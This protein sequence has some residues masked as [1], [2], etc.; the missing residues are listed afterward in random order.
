MVEKCI[1]IWAKGV[2]GL[3]WLW[4]RNYMDKLSDLDFAI[5]YDD[6]I[7]LP[8]FE[9][10]VTIGK[11]RYE[12]N[13]HQQPLD[14]NGEIRN[15]QKKHA[16]RS[17]KIL[18]DSD[19]KV[20][21]LIEEKLE[22]GKLN[23]QETCVSLV[24]QLKWRWIIHAT[25]AVRRGETEAAHLLVNTGLERAIQL[26][27]LLNEEDIPHHKW[28]PKELRKIGV[29]EEILLKIKNIILVRDYE[30]SEA[31]RRI[32]ELWELCETI[33]KMATQKYRITD[34]NEEWFRQD[35]ARQR[36]RNTIYDKLESE[37]IEMLIEKRE[38]IHWDWH[39][40]RWFINLNLLK[41]KEDFFEA[42]QIDSTGIGK[43]LCERLLKFIP[44]TT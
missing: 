8:L 14:Q 21:K 40:I 34:F 6:E 13:I 12:I 42:L 33:E 30:D 43:E 41:S 26:L 11:E 19:G 16:Y 4:M 27:F 39:E 44:I 29:S 23:L 1:A 10:H 20:K 18:Y 38:F 17:G 3:W 35:R 32:L 5:F 37:I 9:F 24:S 7:P 25:N 2:V 28:M 36:T 22:Y 31:V 15:S